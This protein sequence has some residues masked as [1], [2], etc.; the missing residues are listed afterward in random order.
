MK[1]EYQVKVDGLTF[2][3]VMYYNYTP[4]KTSG[5][6]EDCYPEEFDLDYVTCEGV[7]VEDGI[8]LS[9]GATKFLYDEYAEEVLNEILGR[10]II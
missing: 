7:W 10:K 1:Y 8:Y 3:G 9:E 5:M 4:A 6:P 2:E